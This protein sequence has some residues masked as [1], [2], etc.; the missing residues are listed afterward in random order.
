MFSKPISL[1]AAFMSQTEFSLFIYRLLRKKQPLETAGVQHFTAYKSDNKKIAANP[2]KTTGSLSACFCSFYQQSDAL[3]IKKPKVHSAVGQIVP[4]PGYPKLG[5]TTKHQ[6]RG[7]TPLIP[8][9]S[10]KG[11]SVLQSC[12]RALSLQFLS[13]YVIIEFPIK[14]NGEYLYLS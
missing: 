14:Q 3:R 13:V 1:L 8:V 7:S 4:L 11:W 2:L 12:R 5:T 9:V 10:P 6:Y